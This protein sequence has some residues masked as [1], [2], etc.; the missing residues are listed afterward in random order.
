MQAPQRRWPAKA[1]KESLSPRRLPSHPF[2]S[3]VDV[4]RPN[5]LR[6]PLS[7]GGP[8][9]EGDGYAIRWFLGLCQRRNMARA[10]PLWVATV[11][12]GCCLGLLGCPSLAVVVRNSARP[13]VAGC[14]PAWPACVQRRPGG[15]RGKLQA[16]RGRGGAANFRE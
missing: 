14:P 13:N 4:V 1:R 8:N 6:A 15:R 3:S 12:D 9:Q 2:A 10:S 16:R 11:G 7:V 5:R